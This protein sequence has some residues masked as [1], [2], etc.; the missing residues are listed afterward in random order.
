MVGKQTLAGLVFGMDEFI[1]TLMRVF[2]C[3]F[4]SFDIFV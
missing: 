2:N 3:V 4:G 1:G